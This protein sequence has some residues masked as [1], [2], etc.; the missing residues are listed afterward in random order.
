MNFSDRGEEAAYEERA[1]LGERLLARGVHGA[2]RLR[3]HDAARE[4]ELLGVD[5]AALQG[6]GS[7]AHF[8]WKK[9]SP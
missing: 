5:E 6:D 2:D 8:F 3:A 7:G 1:G 4:A 9:R